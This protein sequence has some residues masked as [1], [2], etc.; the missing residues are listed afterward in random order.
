MGLVFAALFAELV[1]FKLQ[2]VLALKVSM[3]VI[4]E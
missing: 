4:I 1:Q 3:R 2:A